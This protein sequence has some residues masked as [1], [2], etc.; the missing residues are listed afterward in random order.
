MEPVK[1]KSKTSEMFTP[2]PQSFLLRSV[3]KDPQKLGTS[4]K[5]S[6]LTT[7]KW[8]NKN[9]SI[10]QV[11]FLSGSCRGRAKAWTSCSL[12]QSTSSST[13]IFSRW[14]KCSSCSLADQQASLFTHRG[15]EGASVAQ[16]PPP[17]FSW[18]SFLLLSFIP[19]SRQDVVLG[20]SVEFAISSSK[21]IWFGCVWCIFF[22]INF[23]VTLLPFTCRSAFISGSQGCLLQDDRGRKQHILSDEMFYSVMDESTAG[24]RE[25]TRDGLVASATLT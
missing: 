8:K 24:T 14:S 7:K 6:T 3:Q 23:C 22:L 10:F 25:V 9:K 20:Q 15:N 2:L 4:A 16:S 19:F 17:H 5:I 21:L 18:P 11:I 12:K 13:G 1:E